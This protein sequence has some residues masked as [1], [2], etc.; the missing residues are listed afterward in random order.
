M[1]LVLEEADL[2]A[3][4]PLHPRRLRKRGFS[5]AE[6]LARSAVPRHRRRAIETRV[7]RRLRDTPEQAGL[8]RKE[9]RANVQGAFAARSVVGRRVLLVDDVV[10]TCS[11]AEA[12]AEALLDA[13]AA[14]VEV[15][16]LARAEH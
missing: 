13:G 15:L 6:A 4:V 2:V 14:S 7:L 8:G 5:Q 16:A 9:R 3:P 1:R 11:T 10:T 12:A